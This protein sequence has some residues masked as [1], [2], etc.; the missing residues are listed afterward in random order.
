MLR[1][2]SK[3]PLLQSLQLCYWSRPTIFMLPQKVYLFIWLTCLVLLLHFT[4]SCIIL[5]ILSTPYQ[6]CAFQCHCHDV[7]ASLSPTI[8]RLV[9]WLK[10][11]SCRYCWCCV[12]P[13]E[14]C[15]NLVL[16]CKTELPWRWR[17]L[18]KVFPR[19]L[20]NTWGR[21]PTV[22]GYTNMVHVHM[23][24]QLHGLK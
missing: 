23:L 14:M 10:D 15:S 2:W 13:K 11:E 8:L 18:C 9:F 6:V 5:C 20:A 12:L 4:P 1:H 19:L 16:T 24:H 21:S 17:L 3:D 7:N 22:R